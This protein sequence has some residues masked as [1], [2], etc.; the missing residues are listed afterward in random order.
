VLCKT[1]F[2]IVFV[3]AC[4]LLFVTGCFE[5]E[6]QTSRTGATQVQA[7]PQV[8]K[9]VNGLT[10]E[11]QNIWDRVEVTT[12]PTKVMWIHLIALNG[13]IIRRMPVRNKV[14]SSGKRLE[15]KH[16][17][18]YGPN[19]GFI[20]PKKNGKNN[21]DY[22]STD[23]FIGPDGTLGS[24]DKYIFWFDPMHRYH[25]WG[26]AGGLGYLITD[27]PIDVE[28]PVDS[29]TGLYNMHK[30]AHKWQL[31]QEKKIAAREVS[32]KKEHTAKMAA[33]EAQIRKNNE[34]KGE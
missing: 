18:Q 1:Q 7:F 11:Q 13:K 34:E 10:C 27:Y 19:S 21:S 2:K 32:A 20:K 23:E 30:A 25:Q 5:Y 24:S 33:L 14:T 26:T 6:L 31:E 28:N 29:I 9:N 4:T 17:S 22:Y 16:Y 8:P 15:P 3:I 12:D